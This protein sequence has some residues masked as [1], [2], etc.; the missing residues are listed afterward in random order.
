MSDPRQLAQQAGS[1]D[2]R[3]WQVFLENLSQVR[4]Q[5]NQ[6]Q[7]VNLPKSPSRDQVAEWLAKQHFAADPGI[8]DVW[9]LPDSPEQE[10]RLIEVNALLTGLSDEDIIPVDFGFDV[11]GLNYTLL[12]VDVTPDQWQRLQAGALP[13]PEHWTLR[14]L[15]H[16]VG[17]A[18]Q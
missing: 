18:Q 5:H 13:L 6:A 2:E 12:V 11:E 8:T 1:L 7:G 16:F 15:R 9:Y 14:D 3:Q 17:Y 10:I 4:S